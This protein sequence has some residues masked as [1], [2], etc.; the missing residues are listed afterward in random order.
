MPATNTSGTFFFQSKKVMYHVQ[1][2]KFKRTN[3]LKHH[4]DLRQW[5]SDVSI[6]TW[7]FND[8]HQKCSEQ[9]CYDH[10]YWN[11]KF[12]KFGNAQKEQF[13]LN[14]GFRKTQGDVKFEAAR[15]RALDR[16]RPTKPTTASWSLNGIRSLGAPTYPRVIV[17]TQWPVIC[18]ARRNIKTIGRWCAENRWNIDPSRQKINK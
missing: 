5:E 9:A 2:P 7:R 12:Q 11:G 10:N 4:L 6:K 3:Q 18:A 1:L 13:W 15:F 14:I 17:F 16:Y 8:T